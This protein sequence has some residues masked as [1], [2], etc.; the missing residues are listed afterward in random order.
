MLTKSIKCITIFKN[1][2]EMCY[3]IKNEQL[4]FLFQNDQARNF[5][6]ANM[7]D[8]YQKI[9]KDCEEDLISN[10]LKK[11]NFYEADFYLNPRTVFFRDPFMITLKNIVNV[12]DLTCAVTGKKI[13]PESKCIVWVVKDHKHRCSIR[14]VIRDVE[15][16]NLVLEFGTISKAAEF[17][18]KK[19]VA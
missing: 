6:D 9:R 14:T 2:T 1:N 13:Y 18:K 10:P 3:R 19:Q 4:S 11:K 8:A 17:L 15:A 12:K 5:M 16:F 7:L